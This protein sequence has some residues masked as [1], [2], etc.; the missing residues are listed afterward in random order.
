[1]SAKLTRL[2]EVEA[3]TMLEKVRWPDGPICPHC[4]SNETTKLGGKAGEKGQYK[5]RPCRKKFTVRVGTIFEESPIPLRDWV[6]AFTRMCASKKGISAHQLHRELGVTYKT[7]WFMCHRV[8]HAMTTEGALKLAGTIEADETYV[9]GKPRNRGK[10]NIKFRGHGTKKTPVFAA[11]QRGG[12]VRARVLPK[13]NAKNLRAAVDDAVDKSQSR[14]MTDDLASDRTIGR[15]FAGGHKW[16]KHSA[17][18]YARGD[19]HVNTCESFFALIKRG[20][21]GTFHH[22]SREHLHRYVSEFVFRYNGRKLNDVQR[23]FPA[24]RESQGKRLLYRQP[25]HSA[26]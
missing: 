3:R 23:T 20:V 6:Y 11:I 7:A 21:Y 25:G 5:C 4:E 2:N 19:C 26:A 15:T 24:L 8:R 9:G 10:H 1:M 16:I 14:L 18:E 12:E 13:V 17:E 22:V